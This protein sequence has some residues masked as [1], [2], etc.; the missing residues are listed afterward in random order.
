MLCVWTSVH[1]NLPEHGKQNAQTYRRKPLWVLMGLFMP[2][3]VTWNAFSQFLEARRHCKQMR[4][5]LGQPTQPSKLEVWRQKHGG[6]RSKII[7]PEADLEVTA[8]SV[9]P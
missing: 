7:P 9:S 3:I 8:H 5:L 2:E 6:I 4:R 1:L